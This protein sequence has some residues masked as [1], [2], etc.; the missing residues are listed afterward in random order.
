MA[1]I[2]LEIAIKENTAVMGV[3]P[4]DSGVFVSDYKGSKT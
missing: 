1:G 4:E 3:I 2:C